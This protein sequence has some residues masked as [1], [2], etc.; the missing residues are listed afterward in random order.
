MRNVPILKA[1][2]LYKTYGQ[3][4][5]NLVQAVADVS[6]ELKAGELVMISGPNGSGKTTLLSLLGCMGKPSEGTIKILEQEVTTLSQTELTEFRLKNIGFIFQSFRLLNFLTVLENV[7][8][9]LNLG[10]KAGM[11]AHQR[12]KFLLEELNIS[13]RAD[14][15]PTAL[16]GGEK[17]RVAIARALANDPPL[18]LADEPTGSLDYQTGQSVIQL[19]SDVAKTHQKAVA[20]VT[21]DPRIEHYADRILTMEGGHLTPR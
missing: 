19:L 7:K 4:Q 9:I 18:L 13:H 1:D 20:I 2:H 5:V 6:L 16:S 17:Q 21:H 8:L 15:F 10:G 11:S 14:F 12:A 3:K